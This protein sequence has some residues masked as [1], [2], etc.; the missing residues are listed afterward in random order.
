MNDFNYDNTCL[1]WTK[2]L[3][4]DSIK[5]WNN[6][7]LGLKDIVQQEEIYK[8]IFMKEEEKNGKI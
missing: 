8:K 2:S 7:Y 4:G 1:I 6:K 3:F 5:E